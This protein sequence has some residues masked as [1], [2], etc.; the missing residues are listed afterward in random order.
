M[1]GWSWLCLQP[2]HRQHLL[3]AWARCLCYWL[4]I[5]GRNKKSKFYSNLY[6]YLRELFL[7][8]YNIRDRDSYI[9]ILVHDKYS[10][11]SPGQV[12]VTKT[13]CNKAENQVSNNSKTLIEQHEG[14]LQTPTVARQSFKSSCHVKLTDSVSVRSAQN[15]SNPATISRG[16][17]AGGA[18]ILTPASSGSV[19]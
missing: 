9:V 3:L 14:G 4:V 5:V 11:L 12:K 10:L 15:A 2:R 7:V 6:K 16:I 13:G 1:T 19:R 8:F 18:H 17:C